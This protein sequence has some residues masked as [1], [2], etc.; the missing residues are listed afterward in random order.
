MLDTDISSYIIRERPESVRAR[1]REV[2]TGQLCLSVV[3]E[4]ELLYGVKVRGSPRA[5]AST[6][7]DFLRRLTVLDWSRTAAQHYADIRAKL[8][9]A[10]TP[11]GNMDLM[12]AAHARSAGAVLVTNNEKHF[13]RV[14]GLKLE[15]WAST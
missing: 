5:L 7:A 12:I 9:S 15:N 6:V 3:S 11:I 10:G 4:A 8:E 14:P 2:D 1:F 13:R